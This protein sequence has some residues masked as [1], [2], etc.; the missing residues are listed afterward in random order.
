M[1]HKNQT[2]TL[3]IESVDGNMQGV[4]RFEGQTIF[5]PGALAGETVLAAATRCEKRFA[6]ARI[7]SIQEESPCR[8]EPAC[9]YY[10][11]CGGCSALHMAYEETLRIK[12]EA[13]R[14]VLR[15]VGG[16]EIDVPLPLSMEHPFAYRN[17]TALPVA[18]IDGAPKAGF[19][20]PRSHRLIPV[21]SCLIARPEGSL[22]ANTV[23]AWMQRYGIAPYDE[24]AGQGLIRH[25]VTRTSLAGETMVTLAVSADDVPYSGELYAMLQ[26][27][28]PKTVSL[29]VSVNPRKDNVILGRDY[30]VLC[31]APRLQDTLCGL[32]F[33][34]S[35][36]SF[37]QVNPL[38][39]EKLYQTALR[40]ADPKP[41]ELAVDLY[42]GAGTISLM[43]ARHVRKV[44]GIEIVPEAIRDARGN[45]KRNGVINAEFHAAAAEEL[46]PALADSGLRP[47]LVLLDPPR[48][49]AEPAVIAAIAQI[50]PSRVVYISC[51]PAT[52]ARDIRL[53]ADY[54]YHAETVQP[55]DMFCWTSH[56]ET[57]VKL[58]RAGLSE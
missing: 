15:R 31:G 24:A 49:G 18:T 9:P 8:R 10:R 48:K 12:R 13:V 40:M 58:T 52:L 33:S 55:V 23:C 46:L 35:P 20:A 54:G 56:V 45:A 36:L 44:I 26:A 28:V 38:Q 1:L 57:V 21:D 50:H 51:D 42:C 22:A 30:R 29:C 39:T 16:T 2:L 34:L 25:V 47:G 4:A 14:Q 43:L 11:Q 7:L 5:V 53:F 19:Y 32:T 37:F 41:E 27:A 3:R 6:F 17:K